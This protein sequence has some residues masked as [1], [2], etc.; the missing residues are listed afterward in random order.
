MLTNSRIHI[1]IRCT[2]A[3]LSI[4]ID[5]TYIISTIKSQHCQDSMSKA[6]NPQLHKWHKKSDSI[7]LNAKQHSGHSMT[8]K[9][10]Y[11]VFAEKQKSFYNF[12]TFTALRLNPSHHLAQ[13]QLSFIGFIYTS[14]LIFPQPWKHLFPSFYFTEVKNSTEH[15]PG[16]LS[17]TSGTYLCNKAD[18]SKAFSWH[19]KQYA[20]QHT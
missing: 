6:L 20:V 7:N 14:I 15:I 16:C 13:P 9:V 3:G 4:L 1:M 5:R 19:W 8:F 18:R 12:F 10:L 17:A 2:N 11:L